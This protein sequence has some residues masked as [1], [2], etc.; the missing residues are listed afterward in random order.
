MQPLLP[1]H[2][3]PVLVQMLLQLHDKTAPE[4]GNL[5]T[6][7]S[8]AVGLGSRQCLLRLCHGQTS[9]LVATAV[10]S[11]LVSVSVTSVLPLSLTP[12]QGHTGLLLAFSHLCIS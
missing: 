10:S 2:P 3:S 4:R 1:A 8:A 9:T 7:L 6:F 11:T 12:D 5:S